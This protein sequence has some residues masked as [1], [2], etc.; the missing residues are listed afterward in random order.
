LIK[1]WLM[2][3]DIEKENEGEQLFIL[4]AVKLYI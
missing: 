4:E 3:K 2:Q 1:K